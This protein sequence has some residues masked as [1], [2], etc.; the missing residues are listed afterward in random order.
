MTTIGAIC[1]TGNGFD[2]GVACFFEQTPRISPA[3]EALTE[4][5]LKVIK[6]LAALVSE[7]LYVVDFHRRYFRF[8]ATHDLFADFNDTSPLCGKC[9]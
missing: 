8:V 4:H 5:Q 6:A 1:D 2:S 3:N 7:E 9:T